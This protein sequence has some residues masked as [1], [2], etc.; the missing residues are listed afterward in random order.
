MF[1]SKEDYGAHIKELAKKKR[2]VANKVQ[3]LREN[4][5]KDDWNRRQMFNY[6]VRNVMSYGTEIWDWKEK[7]ELEKI[8]MD[9]V[10]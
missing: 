2:I 1:N 8:M 3:G 6:L 4:I 5:C 10:S 9:Y 7:K